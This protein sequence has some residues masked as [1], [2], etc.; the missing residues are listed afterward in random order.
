MAPS[1]C[2]PAA[3]CS[4]SAARS[5]PALRFKTPRLPRGRGVFLC[6][7]SPQERRDAFCRLGRDPAKHAT[8]LTSTIAVTPLADPYLRHALAFHVLGLDPAYELCSCIAHFSRD[9]VALAT[10][11]REQCFLPCG[12]LHNCTRFVCSAF[13]PAHVYS[14]QTSRACG[15]SVAAARQPVRPNNFRRQLQDGPSIPVRM[16]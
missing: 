2:E 10:R 5:R 11:R 14:K 1:C 7:A 12:K 15:T 16:A 8:V 13:L 9:W 3:N 4:V 6:A